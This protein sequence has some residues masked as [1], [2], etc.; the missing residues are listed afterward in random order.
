MAKKSL[1]ELRQEMY[2][3]TLV[4]AQE[5]KRTAREVAEG[6]EVNRHWYAKF[7]Q[8]R[9]K[10]PDSASLEKLYEFLSK[11][12]KSERQSQSTERAAARSHA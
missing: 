4:L 1:T 2:D 5:D 9:A 6:A 7:R 8:G 3:K 12:N 11:P 10:N